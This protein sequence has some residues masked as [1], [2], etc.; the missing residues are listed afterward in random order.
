MSTKHLHCLSGGLLAQ[1]ALGADR[2]CPRKGEGRMSL[3][4]A[5]RAALYIILA[6]GLQSTRSYHSAVQTLPI[7]KSIDWPT[8]HWTHSLAHLFSSL[9]SKRR[10][11]L[12]GRLQN[13]SLTPLATRLDYTGHAVVV[14]LFLVCRCNFCK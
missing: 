7:G 9:Q 10:S 11:S 4:V 5:T 8:D 13:L 6:A 1:R 2:L 14:M 12:L 3:H